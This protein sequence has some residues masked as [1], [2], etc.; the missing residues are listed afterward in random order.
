[1]TGRRA[2]LR[3]DASASIGTGHVV[4]CRTL[5]EA[6]IAHGWRA[7]LVAREL[8][9]GLA[10]G[11]TGTSFDV[12][13]LGSESSTG[14]EPAEIA[15]R[16]GSDASL[17]VGDDYRLGT[18]WFLGV[19]RNLPGAIVMAID[20]L[21]DRPLPV[22]L[23]LNQNIG[24]IASA[25]V[26]LVPA[27]A[28][29]L[30]GPAHALLRPQFGRL[31]ARGRIRDGRVERILVFMSGADTNDVTA[32]AVTGVGVLGRPLDVVVGAAY[33]HLARLRAIIA[34]QPETRL[35]VNTDEMADLMER[36]DLAVGAASSAS[37]E[38]CA[39]GL[40]AVLVT[41]ADNQIV[42]E[43]H[44][45]E[46]G[47]AQAIGWHTEI[48][49]A[50]IE[51]AVRAL[52]ADPGRVAAMSAAAAAVTDGLGTERVVAEIEAMVNRGSEAR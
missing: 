44:L 4:R 46:T 24:A 31:R 33:P 15:D 6:L 41:L 42:A 22:D 7:T 34:T 8:P 39:L 13:R 20:D 3:A 14:T 17:V 32:R 18:G 28:R 26:G 16:V 10:E 1:M 30:A 43:R 12:V 5:A 51:H 36:A 35:H 49:A 29:V 19:R 52:C 45:V 48:T 2:I 23:V 47:A 38:R 9:A 25:Y 11:P 21:A 50:D 40:P 27:G 37:W